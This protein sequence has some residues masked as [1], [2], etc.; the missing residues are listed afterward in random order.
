ML[1]L[2]SIL[3]DLI[4]HTNYV[5]FKISYSLRGQPKIRRHLSIDCF[6]WKL[7]QCQQT[8]GSETLSKIMQHV[9]W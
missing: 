7:L 2:V 6:L 1:F 5:L 4:T 9:S 8:V 3:N